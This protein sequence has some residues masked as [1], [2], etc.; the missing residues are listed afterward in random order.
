[1]K[2]INLHIANI[3]TKMKLK[4]GIIFV[5]NESNNQN[6]FKNIPT[7][8]KF[9]IGDH[10]YINITTTPMVT[11]DI[12]KNKDKNDSW[13]SN[14]Q[15][16]FNRFQLFQLIRSV[17]KLIKA[18]NNPNINLF[19]YRNKQLMINT[20][21]VK[22][23]TLSVNGSSNKTAVIEPAVIQVDTGISTEYYEGINFYINTIDNYIS[24]TY[25]EFYYLEYELSKLDLNEISMN[26]TRFA[27]DIFG[28]D[29]LK[30]ERDISKDIKQNKE[31]E[32][33][34][35]GT[36]EDGIIEPLIVHNESRI[37]DIM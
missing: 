3:G 7:V 24:L 26:A 12:S 15:I 30:E 14:M 16:S 1:M 35:L 5:P 18:F 23:M 6:R 21:I 19:M 33:I 4:V 10:Q 27:L 32:L 34:D 8:N 20:S 22:Q 11:I 17:R 9:T 29:K 13:S 36:E 31:E 2:K 37:P 25:D 28:D